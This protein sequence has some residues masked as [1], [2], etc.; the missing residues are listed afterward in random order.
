MTRD[1]L[2]H[3]QI[4]AL[5]QAI[6]TEGRVT[7]VSDRWLD[8]LGYGRSQVLGQPWQ[9]FLAPEA[10]SRVAARELDPGAAITGPL[11]LQ[12]TA[13]AAILAEAAVSSV[14]DE[15]GQGQ[16][17]LV[18]WTELPTAIGEGKPIFRLPWSITD[19]TTAESAL[20]QSEQLLQV[21]A[22]TVEDYFWI[23][24]AVDRRPLYSSPKLEGVWGIPEAALQDTLEPLITVV[25]ADDRAAF[26]QFIAARSQATEPDQLEFRIEHAQKGLRWLRSRSYPLLDSAGR[27]HAVVGVTTDITEQKQ[28]A[29]H[30]RQSEERFRLIAEN[31]QDYFWIDEADQ[32]SP[33][34]D[35]PNIEKVWGL[36]STDLQTGLPALVDRVHPDDRA[37]FVQSLSQQYQR[38]EP[39]ENTF[40]I[41]HP[42]GEVRWLRER[43]FPLLDEQGRPKRIV[44]VTADITEQQRTLKALE[45]SE[46]RFRL[47]ADHIQDVFWLAD[48]HTGH[49]DYISPAFETLWQLPRAVL[50]A[51]PMAFLQRVHPADRDRVQANIQGRLADPHDFEIEYRLALP[52][53]T[54]R[55]IRDRGSII[56]DDQGTPIKMAGIAT[57]I[58][59]SHQDA[60]RLQ[61]Y[62]R[63]IAAN[64]DPVC[65]IG[66][67]YTYRL[68]NPAFRAWFN[69]GVD[70]QGQHIAACFGRDFFDTI[71]K[72]R[73]DQALAGETQY[74]EEWAVNP[75]QDEPKFI[76]ITYAPYYEANGEISG[77]INSIR[78]LTVLKQT[79]DRLSQMTD[80]LRLHIHNSPLAVIE[81]NDAQRI[82]NWSP[83]A[84]VFFGWSAADMLGCHVTELPIFSDA[85]IANIPDY[86]HGLM[87]GE[88]HPQTA[89]T[90]NLTRDGREIYCEWHNSV[91]TDEAGQVISILSLVQD[92]TDRRRTQL[93]LQASEERWQ[94]AV[95]GSN[96]GIW[97]WQIPTNEVYYSPR[98]KELLGYTD[99]E[100]KNTRSAWISRVHPDDMSYV[101]ATMAT[102]LQGQSE[103]YQSEY[104]MRHKSGHYIWILSRGRAIFDERGQAVRFVG[105]H[106]D[107]SDRKQAELDLQASQELLQL[108]FDH[109][110]QRVFWKGLDGRF[111]GCNRAFA[112]DM[113]QPDPQAVIGK[114][115]EELQVLAPEAVQIFRDRDRAVISTKASIQFAEQAQHYADGTVRW[116]STI[117][118]PFQTPQGELLGIFGSYEDITERVQAKRSLQRYAHMVEAARDAICLLDTDYRYQVINPTYRDWYGYNGQPIL[119]Q[120]VAEV[121]GQSAFEHRLKSLLERCLQGETIQ[122]DRWFEFPHLGQRFRSV[123]L[124]PYREETGEITG[125]VT[126]IR[127]LTALKHSEAQQQQLFE[128]IEATPDLVAMALPNGQVVY[129]N[130][131]LEQFLHRDRHNPLPL[132]HVRHYYPHWA[133]R[134]VLQEAVPTAIAQGTWQGETALIDPTGQAVPVSQTVTVHLNEQGEV[135][136]LS[137]IAR[138]I[139][140]QKALEQELRDRLGFEQLLSRLSTAFVDL[141][142]DRLREGITQALQEIAI[143]TGSERSYVYLLSADQQWGELLG[144]W[145]VAVLEPIAEPWHRVPAA[146]FPWWMD[147][148]H[149][150]QVIA[151]NDVDQLPP[152]ADNERQAMEA[153]GTRSLAVVPMVYSQRLIGHIGFAVTHP[154]PWSENEI[155]L[156]RIVGDLFANAYQR[157]QVESALRHQEHYYRRLTENASDLV[158]LLDQ[159]GRVQYVTPSVTRLLGYPPKQLRQRSVRELV[160][161]AD[162][163][164]LRAI[165][166]A[167]I[168]QPGVPQPLVQCRVWH[169]TEQQWR[170]FE[171]V[172][173]SLLADP[174]IGGLVVNCRDVSDRVAAEAA[175]RHSEQVFQAIFEQSAISMAQIALDGTYIKVNPA[176]CQLV[177]Y[178]AEE[179]IGEHYAKVTHPEDLNYDTQMSNAVARGDVPAE[180]IDKRFV[181]ADG[182]VRHVQVVVTAVQGNQNEPAFLSSVYNDVTEQVIAERSLR[183]IVEGTAAVTGEAFFPVLARQLANTLG[184]DHI[185]INQ[186]NDDDTLTTLIFWSHQRTQAAVTYH[187]ADTPCDR[188]LRQGFYCCPEQVQ[189][190]F[191]EDQDLVA[192]NAESYIGVALQNSEGH[193][194]G[195]ICV[196]HSQPIQN[197]DTAVALLRIFAARASAELERQ[198]SNLALKTSEANWRNILENMPILLDAVDEQGVITLWNKECERVTGYTAAEVIGNPEAFTRFY[199]DA[200]HRQAHMESWQQRRNNYRNWEWTITCKDG[201]ERVIAWSNISDLYPIPTLGIWGVGVDVTE[202]YRAEAALRQ[203]EARFQRLAANMPGVIYRYHQYPDGSDRFSYISP[204]SADLWEYA[205]EEIYADATKLWHLLHPDDLADFQQSLADALAQEQT[206]FHEHRIVTPSGRLKWIQG[207]AKAEPQSDGSYAWDGVLIDVTARKQAETEL[208]ASE[209]R[210]QRLARNTPGIIYRYHL[211]ADGRDRFS[212]LSR[213]C[214]EIW[215]IAPEVVMQ[216]SAQAWNLVHPDDRDRIQAA[217]A[218]SAQ[219]LTPLSANY[220]IIVPSNRQKWLKV[221]ARP[222]REPNGDCL[223]DGL[224]ID[225]TEQIA[226]Q[227]AL[228]QSEA[229]NRAIIEALPDLLI[230]LRRDGL[231]LDMYY[232]N[233]FKVLCPKERHVGRF[234]QDTLATPVA[235]QRMQAVERA[236]ATGEM[237]IY[238]YEVSINGELRWEEARVVPM[239]GDEVLVLVRDIDDRKRAEAAL[240]QSEALNRAI[241]DALPDMLVRMTLDGRCLDAHHPDNFPDVSR[242][243]DSVGRNVRELLP[244]DLAAERIARAQVAI[245]TQQTQVCE[246]QLCVD[247]QPRWEESRIV[248]LTQQEVLVLVRDV[249]ER[250]RAEEEVRRLNRALED[251][252][253]R[254]E[255]LVELRTA[256][257]VTFMN[258]LP[259][260]I[261]VVD[262]AQN[263]M[264]FGNQVV[265]EFAQKRHR[266]EFEGKNVY[267]C[268]DAGQAA[269]Y[270]QQNQQ[271]FETGEVLHVEEA[272]DTDEGCIY[273]DTYKIPLKRPDGEV[274]ALIGTSRDVTELVE[275]RQALE[276]QAAQLEATNQELQSFSYS[277][278]HDLRAPLR[279]VN[280]FIAALKQRLETTAPTPDPKVAHYLE[281]IEKSSHKMG[282]LID[283]LLTLSRVS[284]RDMARHP[285]PL[286]PLVEQAIALLSDSPEQPLEQVQITVDDLPTVEGDTALLQQV[287]SNLIGNAVKFS[288]DR[289]PAIIHVGCQDDHTFFVRDNGVGFDMA[290]AD[291][292]FSPFQRLHKQEEFQ[293]TGIGLAIVNRIIHRHDGQIWVESELDRGTTFYFTLPLPPP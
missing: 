44:G 36:S 95:S 191:P 226:T 124:T 213:A 281:V 105:S 201:S 195:E 218:Q 290:Y 154:K 27:P 96:E 151:I 254:L 155:A 165:R 64:P 17:Y 258:T 234:V 127:D 192:F 186:L 216:D 60:A 273:L 194:L 197:L 132:R 263:I 58:T 288:R 221:V 180:F 8:W 35:S 178:S 199:P 185:L 236:T 126:N 174:I 200:R 33:L 66:R 110:P 173:T 146:P 229:L 59:A 187:R 166:R 99:D 108:M 139:R 3:D 220:R 133:A 177:G 50:D 85:V 6:D 31:I 203:S 237:Q 140:P 77:V 253:Q 255:E 83:Q 272:V 13:G 48:L 136:L 271:V 122:Y 10:R 169:H 225:V 104:R 30:L 245:A 205:P 34:Y 268:F 248:P 170:D 137:S 103:T 193:V 184:V 57:D 68:S 123:T 117:K 238:E 267:D 246:Y 80:R 20:A 101:Q 176:F 252:N 291:K 100:L 147:Q 233:Y 189:A 285:V 167:A 162:V 118:S 94:L 42:N 289:T 163:P 280:G 153:V 113:G 69:Y 276:A 53:G 266:R 12:T 235:T 152:E 4:P 23:D 256:E 275:A 19:G 7:A 215:E 135:K 198:Q 28:T 208:S 212:Y 224:V 227:T 52:D 75:S 2:F 32:E 284:R 63:M 78:D 72:P 211:S 190:R 74:F 292:L 130:P 159:D 115:D 16:T 182:S 18:N 161:P 97:D 1:R 76:S 219:A 202:R 250:R 277:V 160:A 217:F 232:P 142:S 150:R 183:S 56:L 230:R 9:D 81:W 143:A 14:R 93:A 207:V 125:I 259:D 21:I 188:T 46:E 61:E 287:F 119:G 179:L 79:R 261:F 145:H 91:L 11:Q 120:T 89:L 121:L 149:D 282:L 116:V 148:L 45:Q 90:R 247:G 67:D 241:I 47:V 5:M 134:K 92:V 38:I 196:L 25:Q 26:T 286:K 107:V 157:Q 102:H 164:R 172:A 264:S 209:D 106:I 41:C 71:C 54:A 262:R 231:C 222:V 39:F 158:M 175:Q 82:E 55:W 128:I 242:G 269:Q 223:W 109:L 88:A 181:C 251:Q 73:I 240:Q 51:D 274:Y 206:W 270:E 22:A 86:I 239:A 87:R 279:H 265:A 141:P 214:R 49:N 257:L 129:H 168:K 243:H 111:W 62:E 204:G 43:C 24:S 228:Q 249:D 114:T 244:T 84:E 131:A 260:Q 144:Q 156:L 171:V 210:F 293:G 70:I 37:A 283:G 112:L 138:D 98:W 278:S 40:R 65:L 15:A 29:A